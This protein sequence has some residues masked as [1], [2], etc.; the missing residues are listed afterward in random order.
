MPAAI[1]VTRFRRHYPADVW[2]SPTYRTRGHIIPFGLFW[3]YY[4]AMESAHAFERI[5]QVKAISAALSL[6][7]AGKDGSLPESLR[8]DL[9]DAF[10]S[11]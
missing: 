7:L 4:R 11:P 10:L 2:R 9:R 5:H 3:I 8:A 1:L 6:S